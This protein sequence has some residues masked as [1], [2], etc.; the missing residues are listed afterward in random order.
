MTEKILHTQKY[1]EGELTIY[2]DTPNEE[3]IHVKQTH[4]KIIIEY[5]GSSLTETEADGIILD[6]KKYPKHQIAIKT[7]DCLPVLFLGKKIAFVHA[8]WRG[9]HNKILTHPLLNELHP[10]LIYLGPSIQEFEVTDEF[11][12]HFPN[13]LYFHESNGKLFFNLQKEAIDQLQ[14]QY[15]KA[16]I[17]QSNICTLRDLNYNSFRRNKTQKRNWNVFKTI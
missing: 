3:V 1:R 2:N 7:A 17:I 13:S 11:K 10:K 6:P 5:Q 9:L 8:G 12:K 15:P 14:K 16:K 4:S